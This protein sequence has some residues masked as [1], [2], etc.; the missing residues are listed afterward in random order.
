M[1]SFLLVID[2]F[3]SLNYFGVVYHG[4]LRGSI[5]DKSSFLQGFGSC[6]PAQTTK[7]AQVYTFIWEAPEM[8]PD[9]AI[10]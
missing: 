10:E 6:K 3:H 8:D 7:E 4:E 9:L 5:C 2:V 1:F